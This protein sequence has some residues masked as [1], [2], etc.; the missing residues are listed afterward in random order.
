MD[1]ILEAI[2]GEESGSK[3]DQQSAKVQE[4]LS[5]LDESPVEKDV[6]RLGRIAKRHTEHPSI[7]LMALRSPWEARK[8]LAKAK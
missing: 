5:H 3:V 7:V 4:I 2:L 1:G 6:Q 8:A